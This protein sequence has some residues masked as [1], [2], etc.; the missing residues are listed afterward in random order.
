MKRLMAICVVVMGLAGCQ[1]DQ[2]SSA[3]R[4]TT[5]SVLDVSG[6]APANA[7]TYT[8]PA[9]TPVYSEQP[10][11]VPP[12]AP[13]VVQAPAPAAP[14]PA[15]ASIPAQAGGPKYTV[16]KG[17]TLYHIAKARYGDGKKWQEIAAANPGV[18]PTSLHVGQTL[19][20]P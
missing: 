14:I 16:R 8:P 2:K 12:P 15:A 20:M 19:V 18:T 1:Q 4:K 17:D 3:A 10:A 11:Y 13:L 9:Y 5:P 7:A 6:P